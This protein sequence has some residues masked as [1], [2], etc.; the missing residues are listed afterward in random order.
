MDG[1]YFII[2]VALAPIVG[3]G[4]MFGETSDTERLYPQLV[5]MPEWDRYKLLAW[6]LF[7]VQAGWSIFAGHKLNTHFR[8]SSPRHV[9]AFFWLGTVGLTFLFFVAAGS[10]LNVDF[11]TGRDGAQVVGA[12]IGTA[13]WA[14]VWTTY[15]LRSKQVRRLY[16]NDAELRD[17][18]EARRLIWRPANWS[19]DQRKMAFFAGAWTTLILIYAGLLDDK[20]DGIFAGDYEYDWNKALMWAVGPPVIVLCGIWLYRRFVGGPESPST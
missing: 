13:F 8:P 11:L 10:F 2:L 16:Y 6:L 9:I 7:A 4:R 19:R 5:G 18:Y 20:Y 17:R 3:F 12:L 1:W 15:L 14:T